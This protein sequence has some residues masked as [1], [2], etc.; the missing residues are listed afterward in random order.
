MVRCAQT[1]G[2]VGMYIAAKMMAAASA[3][4][5]FRLCTSHAV[6]SAAQPAR[7]NTTRHCVAELAKWTSAGQRVGTAPM[8]LNA[9]PMT[10]HNDSHMSKAMVTVRR[11]EAGGFLSMRPN[12]GVKRR[13][14]FR[15]SAWT[16]G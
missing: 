5:I 9:E 11:D 8:K 3:G 15:A 1:M 14:A 10:G 13:A 4:T 2:K 16:M 6:P 12:A 7:K